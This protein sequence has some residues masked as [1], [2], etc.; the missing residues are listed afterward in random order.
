MRYSD[1]K[2]VEADGPEEIDP[3]DEAQDIAG[4]Q[5]SN[6]D[7]VSQPEAPEANN[8]IRGNINLQNALQGLFAGLFGAVLSRISGSNP[9][10]A[11]LLRTILSGNSNGFDPRQILSQAPSQMRGAVEDALD[12]VDPET[13]NLNTQGNQIV[14]ASSTEGGFTTIRVGDLE[15]E[16]GN[17]YYKRGG[18][19]Q[20]VSAASAETIAQSNGWIVPTRDI[21]NA[22]FSNATIVP[23]VTGD[24]AELD[25]RTFTERTNARIREMGASG[26][27]AGHKKDMFRGEDGNIGMI[28]GARQ[29]G[30]FWQ[31]LGSNGRAHA[32][33]PNYDDYS[34]GLR[35]VKRMA[36]RNGED[37]DLGAQQ[38]RRT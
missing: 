31:G 37:V 15:V 7:E 23:M 29:G 10:F 32:R 38:G 16:V 2:I 8:P 27:I 9:M 35:P 4:A 22:I 1:F 17:D 3:N 5:N 6:E 20:R 21:I 19:Y 28:G 11:G 24:P 18:V 12:H 13:G 36:K 25:D 34:Q 33:N 30:G 26:L 14:R